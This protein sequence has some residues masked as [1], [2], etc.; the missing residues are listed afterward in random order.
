ELVGVGAVGVPVGVPAPDDPEAKPDRIR[1]LTQCSILCCS[2]GDQAPRG[3]AYASASSRVATTTVRWLLRFLMRWARPRETGWNRLKTGASSTK[4]SLT[5]RAPSST[6]SS[7]AL[8][9]RFAT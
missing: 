5:T 4:I 8:S 6:R 1:F 9:K 7:S 3:A 2:K